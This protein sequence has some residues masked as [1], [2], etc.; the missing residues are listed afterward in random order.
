M[1]LRYARQIVLPE[2]G[3]E[4]QRRL[5]KARVLV[6]GAGGLGSPLA[7]YLAAAGVGHLG[8]VDDDRVDLSNLQRQ[9]LHETTDIGRKKVASAAD[10]IDDLNPEV[11]VHQCDVRLDESN[12][13]TLFADLRHHCRWQ[14]QFHHAT[15]GRGCVPSHGKNTVSAAVQGFTG[16]ISTFTSHKGSVHPCYRCFNPTGGEGANNCEQAGVLGAVAGVM[17]ATQATEVLKEILG[18]GESLSGRIMITMV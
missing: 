18:I 8:L 3:E 9:V 17:G 6:I 16:Q 15:D 10:A 13:E 2:V 14:R 5:S 11:R 7:L 1:D 12:I 4:G